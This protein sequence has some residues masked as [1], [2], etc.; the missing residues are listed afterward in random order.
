MPDRE[1]FAADLIRRTPIHLDADT[2]PP[3]PW[4]GARE[5]A[6]R[7]WWEPWIEALALWALI[8][9]ICLGAVTFAHFMP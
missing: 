8:G 5:D 7:P 2:L 4:E 6:P 3:L 1:T 9:A